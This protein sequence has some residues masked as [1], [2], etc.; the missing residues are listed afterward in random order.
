MDGTLNQQLSNNTG[1]L[2]K[3]MFPTH[4]HEVT[5]SD[6]VTYTNPFYVILPIPADD[7]LVVS[8]MTLSGDVVNLTLATNEVVPI[9]A[10][11]VMSTGTTAAHPYIIY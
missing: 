11:R 1:K 8:I 10:K 4:C 6:T 7:G 5:K 9:L 3:L 2:T